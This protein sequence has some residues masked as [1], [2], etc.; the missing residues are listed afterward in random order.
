[1]KIVCGVLFYFLCFITN[2][3][4]S[5]LMQRMPTNVLVSSVWSNQQ[6]SKRQNRPSHTFHWIKAS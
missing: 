6:H 2:F 5:D 1:L 3:S 4:M